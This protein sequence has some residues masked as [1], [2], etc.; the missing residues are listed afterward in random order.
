MDPSIHTKPPLRQLTPE[1]GARLKAAAIFLHRWLGVALCL[2]FLMWFSSGFVMMYWE[3]PSVSAAD[4]LIRAPALDP[5]KIRLSPQQ[6]Y[7]QLKTSWPPDKVLLETFD[8]RPVYTFRFGDDEKIVYADD[9]HEQTDFLPEMTLRVASAWTRQ[10]SG[11]AKME[12]LTE[13]DQWTVS[14][15][16]RDLE[17]IR[18]YTWPHGEQV[19]VSTVTGKVVQYTTR[20]TRTGAYFGAIPH[21][22]YFTR[23]RKHARPWSRLVIWSSGLGTILAMLGIVIG[24]WIY[25]PSKR[26]RYAGVPSS[27]P[28]VGQKRWHS[29]LGLS[30]GLFA[31]AWAFSGM[32]SMDPFPGTQEG[33]L[34]EVTAKFAAALQGNL[35]QLDGFAAKPPQEAL[36]QIGPALQ[37]KQLELASFAGEPWY[38]ATGA[39]NQTRIVPVAGEAFAQFSKEQIIEVMER[40]ARP[41]TITQTRLVTE[42]E[43]YYL[44]RH[45]RLP[46]P[47]IFVRLSD[48]DSSSFYID[49]KTA[50]IV[51]SY[52]FHSRWNRWLYHGLHSMDFPWLYK[53]R[54]AWD[55]VVLAL[56]SAGVSLGITSLMLAWSVVRRKMAFRTGKSA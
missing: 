45:H 48:P 37:T 51:Q 16:F 38:L 53:H 19:Y 33:N 54:P 43:A 31:C 1:F 4:R 23:L 27:I 17:P 5:L 35:P 29:I 30:F 41:A 34:D 40:A 22:L 11:T 55:I 10:S 18:K 42:Y 9:G 15:E 25:S 6:A 50:Q 7:S 46:L 12:E 28:Y 56:L 13:E 44:D 26:Y 2:L 3:Y 49:P 21:W 47:V 36:L 32:L 20:A 14:A 39:Q 8:G 24:I 52:N